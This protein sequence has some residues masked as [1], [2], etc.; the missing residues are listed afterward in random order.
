MPSPSTIK[1]RRMC[2]VRTMSPP[3]SR[4]SVIASSRTRLA[5]GVRPIS[6]SSFAGVESHRTL[7][8]HAVIALTRARSYNRFVGGSAGFTPHSGEHAICAS[9]RRL[10]L[11]RAGA[12][13]PTGSAG[14]PRRFMAA[15]SPRSTPG[16]G[17]YVGASGHVNVVPAP[18]SDPNDG[19]WVMP[20]SAVS[21]DG[22][23]VAMTRRLPVTDIQDHDVL[24]LL[25]FDSP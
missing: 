2:C 19:P 1:A 9:C 16:P 5:R 11:G 12:A 6:F 20:R 23:L 3:A 13:P 21:P 18:G 25:P 14:A 7:D 17:E 22:R 8:L 24:L 15:L 4:H 10:A